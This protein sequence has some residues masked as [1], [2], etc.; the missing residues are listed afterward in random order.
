MKK[1]LYILFAV[2]LFA[3]CSSDDGDDNNNNNNNNNQD[4]EFKWNGDWNDP[5]DPNYVKS[6]YNPVLG[7]WEDTS[8]PELRYRYT[9]DLK[10]IKYIQNKKTGIY[11]ANEPDPYIIN[12]TAFRTDTYRFRRY[13]LENGKLYQNVL[14]NSGTIMSDKWYEYKKVTE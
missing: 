10:E 12:N 1:L 7:L 8:D 9:I 14:S 5:N 13:K 3:A 11:E 4:K 2:C 6:G